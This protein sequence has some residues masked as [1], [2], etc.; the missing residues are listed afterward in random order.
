MIQTLM[1]LESSVVL[2]ALLVGIGVYTLALGLVSLYQ[3]MHEGAMA[4]ALALLA[5][6]VMIAVSVFF[7]HLM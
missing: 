5:T 6:L 1:D 3:G 4:Q 7:I 2:T